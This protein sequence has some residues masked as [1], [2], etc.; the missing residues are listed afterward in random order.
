M[1]RKTVK[2]ALMIRNTIVMIFTSLQDCRKSIIIHSQTSIDDQKQD[3]L[4]E[5]YYFSKKIIKF[6]FPHS[7]E[8]VLELEMDIVF[9]FEKTTFFVKDGVVKRKKRMTWI[10]LRNETLSFFLSQAKKMN[11][12]SVR[13]RTKL[14]RIN[15]TFENER[16]QLL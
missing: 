3:C 1:I 10:F 13:K 7:P 14:M 2:L 12:Y 9:F 4:N 15:H 8:L 11:D 6:L 16:K 5:K